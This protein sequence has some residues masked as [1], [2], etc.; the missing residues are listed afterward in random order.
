MTLATDVKTKKFKSKSCIMVHSNFI[1]VHR[2]V[3]ADASLSK[4]LYALLLFV[5]GKWVV[6]QKTSVGRHWPMQN[7]GSMNAP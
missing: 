4:Q 6:V 3:F 2:T 5:C 7:D 1:A